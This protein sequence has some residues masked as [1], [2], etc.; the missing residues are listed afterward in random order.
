MVCLNGGGAG[1]HTGAAHAAGVGRPSLGGTTMPKH[2]LILPWIVV[3][4]T[5]TVKIRVKR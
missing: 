3:I 2:G 4:L 1:V 5:V